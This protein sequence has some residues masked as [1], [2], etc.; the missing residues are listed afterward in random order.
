MF[1]ILLTG[2]LCL[3]IAYVLFWVIWW[4]YIVLHSIKIAESTK[5]PYD[6]IK[7]DSLKQK[8]R[9]ISRIVSVEKERIDFYNSYSSKGTKEYLYTI[10]TPLCYIITAYGVA[11]I[12]SPIELMRLCSYIYKLKRRYEQR[13]S[14]H[15]QGLFNNK[16]N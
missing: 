7:L 14:M 5:T 8:R 4:L 16:F 2:C 10:H 11:I 3:F 1:R 12:S 13:N 15:K 6:Y 9:S